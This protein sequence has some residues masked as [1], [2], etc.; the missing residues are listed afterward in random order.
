MHEEKYKD[1]RD[2]GMLPN[3]EESNQDDLAAVMEA[4][5][6]MAFEIRNP[7]AVEELREAQLLRVRE[8]AK[9]MAAVSKKMTLDLAD[10]SGKQGAFDIIFPEPEEISHAMLVGLLINLGGTHVMPASSMAPDA[11][12]GVDG[13]HAVTMELL[14]NDALR[15]SISSRP[16][17]DAPGVDFE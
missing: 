9:W 13:L 5:H 11:L 14:P 6:E 12:E 1:L 10:A 4:L 2:G 17:V 15:F 16:D 7:V 8:M 3:I